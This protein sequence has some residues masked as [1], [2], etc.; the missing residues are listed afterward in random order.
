MAGVYL[1]SQWYFS[2]SDPTLASDIS[3]ETPI[4]SLFLP[5]WSSGRTAVFFLQVSCTKLNSETTKVCNQKPGDTAVQ[6]SGFLALGYLH[7][8][9]LLADK[10]SSLLTRKSCIL[11]SDLSKP[12]E[13]DV[14][15]PF[16]AVGMEIWPLWHSLEMFPAKGHNLR[17]H[18]QSLDPGTRTFLLWIMVSSLWFKS[19]TNMTFNG[20]H[21]NLAHSNPTVFFQ[22]AEVISVTA[23]FHAYKSCMQPLTEHSSEL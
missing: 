16:F 22:R 23:N 8:S 2:F 12:Q 9:R 15:G 13:L 14:C 1:S 18:T 7:L 17:P 20:E 11:D 10:S 3:I 6:T 5:A 19:K 21:H 4:S